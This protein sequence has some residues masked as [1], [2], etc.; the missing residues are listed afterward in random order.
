LVDPERVARRLERLGGLLAELERI[1]QE[2]SEALRRDARTQLAALH[3]LQVS[4]QIVIDLGAQLVTEAG[5]PVPE[6]YRDVFT[7]LVDAGGIP[8]DLG[9]RLADA[10]SMRNVLVH[11]YLEVELDEV[12]AALERLDDLRRFA[13]IVGE[14]ELGR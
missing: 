9:Q 7:S 3:A 1:R 8:A 5:L 14:R 11:E 12:E 13:R 10:A 2:G 4:L 6:S